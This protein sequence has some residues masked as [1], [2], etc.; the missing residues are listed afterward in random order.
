MARIVKKYATKFD[1][2]GGKGQV[3]FE[4][5][6]PEEYLGKASKLYAQITLHPHSSIGY[7]KHI[8]DGEMYAI[9]EGKGRYNDNGNWVDCK[10]GDVFYAHD[11]EGHGIEN[12]CDEP[13]I[14][15][16]LIVNTIL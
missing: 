14:F 10:A 12:T 4:Y 13:L 16:A 15:T 8:G 3:D 6:L 2:R 11:G 5:V 7:H 1:I 9:V